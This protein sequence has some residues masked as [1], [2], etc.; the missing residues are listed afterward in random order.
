M[1]CLALSTMSCPRA[2]LGELDFLIN[3]AG[4]FLEQAVPEMALV[5]WERLP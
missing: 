1:S 5:D 3:N 4:I 2:Y